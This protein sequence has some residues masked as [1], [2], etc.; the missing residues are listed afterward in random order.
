MKEYRSAAE[1]HAE[2]PC[3]L[4][5]GTFDGVHIGHRTIL[6][7]LVSKAR[8]KNLDSALLTFFP[9][10]RMVLQ[11]ESGIRLLN[12]LDEKRQQLEAIGLDRLIVQPFTREFSRL[13]A[14][15]YVE[16]VLVGQLQARMI[17]IGY[18]HRFGKH[19]SA[20]I[21]DLKR[22]GKEY[23]FEVIE[24]DAQ[25][26]SDVA[27]SSTK[28]RNALH[29]GDVETANQY[30]GYP[31]PV[32]GTIVRGR[33]IGDSKLNYPTANLQVNEDYKLIPSNGV[34]V[35]RS[36]IE[37][38]LVFGI[39]NVGTNPTVGGETT[40]IETHFLDLR[41]DLYNMEVNLE[42]LKFIRREKKFDSLEELKM[43]IA[44]DERFARNFLTNG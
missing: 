37:D 27:V 43:A 34:Y 15:E 35:V 44:E 25:R 1:Y 13:T 8:E 33:G 22:F 20:D 28:I 19:R 36:R 39:T 7:L 29:E 6:E 5:I 21:E 4:T 40:T 42:F 14:R 38:E 24:I 10:P 18:D 3:V 32:K 31:Y 26:I 2:R 9:H 41:K 16:E 30:L 17:I 11:K 12:T 23:H